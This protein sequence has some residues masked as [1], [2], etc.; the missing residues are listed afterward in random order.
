MMSEDDV[1]EFLYK[2]KPA[3]GNSSSG[4]SSHK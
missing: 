3:A 2:W 4:T 1:I